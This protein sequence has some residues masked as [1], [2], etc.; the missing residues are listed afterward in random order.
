MVNYGG[1][2]KCLDTVLINNSVV[3]QELLANDAA[4]AGIMQAQC[5]T[6]IFCSNGTTGF[7]E[8]YFDET[9]P[10]FV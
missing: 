9:I 4:L 2:T 8:V 10:N 1:Q 3:Y 6:Y 7:I 5:V